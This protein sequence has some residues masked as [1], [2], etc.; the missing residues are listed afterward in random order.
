MSLWEEWESIYSNVDHLNAIHEAATFYEKYRT[1]MNEGAE[2]LWPDHEPLEILM[3]M[4][5]ESGRVAF[6]REKQNNHRRLYIHLF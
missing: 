1:E 2:I 5:A 3:K 4:R 6:E